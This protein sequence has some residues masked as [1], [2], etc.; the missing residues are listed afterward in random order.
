[1]GTLVEA[2]VVQKKRDEKQRSEDRRI[3][4]LIRRK[5][6]AH[7]DYRLILNLLEEYGS[8]TIAGVIRSTY[9]PAFAR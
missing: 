4:I 2:D 1:M 8:T 9:D 5:F 6:R 3:R 7:E